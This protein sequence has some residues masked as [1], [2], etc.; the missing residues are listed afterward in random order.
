M[1]IDLCQ[2]RPSGSLNW[3]IVIGYGEERMPLDKGAGVKVL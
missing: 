3:M 2:L 1:P